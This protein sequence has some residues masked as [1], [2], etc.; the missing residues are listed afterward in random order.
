MPDF[1]PIL[2]SLRV[3]GTATLI[4]LLVGA[5]LGYWLT[6]RERRARRWLGAL[7]LLPLMLPPTVLGYYLLVLMGRRG[8]VGRLWEAATGAPLVFTT[9]A[10]VVAACASTIPI[11]TRQ[12]AAAFDEI[13][14][15]LIEA[16]RLDGASGLRLFRHLHL[17]LVRGALLSAGTIAFA[18]AV[19]DFGATLMVAGNIPGETQTAAIAIYELMNAGRDGEAFVMVA[20]ITLLAIGVLAFTGGRGRGG[21]E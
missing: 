15:E 16:A 12:L 1:A 17:P 18:R 19:G 21:A 8:P 13:S 2:L 9:T 6:S 3:A 4:S 14:H 7:V 10:A 20:I 5:I 11:V